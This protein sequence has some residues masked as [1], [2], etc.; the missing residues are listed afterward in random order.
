MAEAIALVIERKKHV[1][2]IQNAAISSD[3][4]QHIMNMTAFISDHYAFELKVDMLAQIACMGETKLRKLFKQ[5]HRCTITEYIQ[6]QRISQAEYLLAHT[7]YPI[8]QVAKSVG[9]TH[10]SHFADLFRKTTGLLPCKYRKMA[11][12][13]NITENKSF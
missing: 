3:D 12:K 13:N 6:N 7:D 10:T 11:Q 9:Y 1:E 4:M 5:V 2:P 8:K